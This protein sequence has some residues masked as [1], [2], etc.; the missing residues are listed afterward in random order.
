MT[1]D[2]THLLDAYKAELARLEAQ[3]LP[4]RL[5]ALQDAVGTL[6]REVC[7]VLVGWMFR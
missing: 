1:V 3:T 6:R 5:Q 2:M 7:T 4:G